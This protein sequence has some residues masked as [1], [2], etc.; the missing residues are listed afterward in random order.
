MLLSVGIVSSC[1][2]SES[3]KIDFKIECIQ[4]IIIDTIN[5]PKIAVL[6]KFTNHSDINLCFGNRYW[7]ETDG[8]PMSGLVLSDNSSNDV[9]VNLGSILHSKYFVVPKGKA[10]H[11]I[12]IFSL[13]MGDSA[14]RRHFN[15]F[16]NRYFNEFGI[17]WPFQL[18]KNCKF[19]YL[20]GMDFG[21][22]NLVSNEYSHV[23]FVDSLLNV[24]R[25][26][27]IPKYLND[28]LSEDAGRLIIELDSLS[29]LE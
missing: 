18:V 7:Q 24:S 1:K 20:S 3:K 16:K 10:K 5:S 13:H 9:S 22:K 19:N 21:T 2:Q 27:S 11:L 23:Y 8:V 29:D 25:N 6:C 14:M 28:M 15:I 26:D 4:T 17:G 12:F